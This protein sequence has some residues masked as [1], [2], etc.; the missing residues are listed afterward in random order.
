M[1]RFKGR[2]M[3]RFEGSALTFPPRWQRVEANCN[4]MPF[5]SWPGFARCPIENAGLDGDD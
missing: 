2:S 4:L 5:I 1:F 3:F